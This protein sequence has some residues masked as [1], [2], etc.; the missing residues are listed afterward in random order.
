[1]SALS[2][3]SVLVLREYRFRQPQ[4]LFPVHLDTNPSPDGGQE[5]SARCWVGGT[6]FYRLGKVDEIDCSAVF[7]E[8]AA[9][10]LAMALSVERELCTEIKRLWRDELPEEWRGRL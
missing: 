8:H 1:M 4:F 3:A 10:G 2:L 5:F 6:G 9:A 7:T